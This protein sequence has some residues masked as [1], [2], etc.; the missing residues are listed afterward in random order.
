MKRGQPATGYVRAVELCGE[1]LAAHFPSQGP[2]E[3]TI[4]DRLLE[5]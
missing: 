2:H 4:S 3:N 1:A 5:I